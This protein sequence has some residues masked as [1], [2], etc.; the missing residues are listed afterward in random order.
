MQDNTIAQ[1]KPDTANMLMPV[2]H[3][4]TQD[5][6]SNAVAKAAHN[7]G[8]VV[9]FEIPGNLFGFENTQAAAIKLNSNAANEQLAFILCDNSTGTIHVLSNDDVPAE[10]LRFIVSY[11]NVL[12]LLKSS[13]ITTH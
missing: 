3:F 7:A 10:V 13:E 1:S 11:K 8:C 9:L 12:S 2:S 5:D 4:K 6:F